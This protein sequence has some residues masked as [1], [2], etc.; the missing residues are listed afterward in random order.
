MN[1]YYAEENTNLSIN[2]VVSNL[3]FYEADGCKCLSVLIILKCSRL[4][5]EQKNVKYSGLKY[6][7]N[8]KYPSLKFEYKYKYQE[9]HVWLLPR[10]GTARNR[11][12][13][14]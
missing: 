11:T 14:L 1:Y 13:D 5:I 7:Y 10:G 8:Y 2:V 9:L 4:F 12:C 6:K 3:L